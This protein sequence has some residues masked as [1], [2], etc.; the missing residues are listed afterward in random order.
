MT[1]LPDGWSWLGDYELPVDDD[2][3]TAPA[4]TALPEEDDPDLIVV[5]GI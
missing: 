2:E 1:P 5:W 4:E 3:A